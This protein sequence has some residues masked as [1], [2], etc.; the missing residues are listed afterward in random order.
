MLARFFRGTEFRLA[1]FN[2]DVDKSPVSDDLKTSFKSEV[3]KYYDLTQTRNNKLGEMDTLYQRISDLQDQI[4]QRKSEQ[5]QLQHLKAS[6]ADPDL[7]QYVAMLT[8]MSGAYLEQMR[9]LVWQEAG[10]LWL[11]SLQQPPSSARLD[12]ITFTDLAFAHGIIQGAFTGRQSLAPGNAEPFTGQTASFPLPSGAVTGLQ[13]DGRIALNLERVQF[14]STWYAI[15]ATSV[16]VRVQGIQSFSATLT[17]PGRG[18][19]ESA[20]PSDPPQTFSMSPRTSTATSQSPA[21]LGAQQGV[22]VG[23]SPFTQWLLAFT[24][25]GASALHTVTQ[26]DLIF[27]GTHRTRPA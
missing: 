7:N 21:D 9:V 25:P 6:N 19:F 13:K 26:I 4:D 3:K 5:L 22:Y 23:M 8:A 27:S 1:R 20:G 16:E 17:H 11:W 14:P 24:L 15:Y 10:A 2:S 18:F 12:G